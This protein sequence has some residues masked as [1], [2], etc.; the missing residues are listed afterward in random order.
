M[1]VSIVQLPSPSLP[2]RQPELCVYIHGTDSDY[3]SI[4]AYNLI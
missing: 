3:E 4:D 1:N 2:N